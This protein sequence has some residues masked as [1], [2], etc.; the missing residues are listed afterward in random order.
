MAGT[1]PRF[2]YRPFGKS[3]ND[4]AHL[5]RKHCP[6]TLDYGAPIEVQRDRHILEGETQVDNQVTMVGRRLGISRRNQ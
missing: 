5:T 2:G 1:L 3:D 4:D 6:N